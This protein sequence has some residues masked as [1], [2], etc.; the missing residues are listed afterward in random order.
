MGGLNEIFAKNDMQNIARELLCM[1][2]TSAKASRSFAASRQASMLCQTGYAM[3]TSLGRTPHS[4]HRSQTSSGFLLGR[5]I[6]G[7]VTSPL[8]KEEFNRRVA[9]L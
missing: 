4:P 8:P 3:E 5:V 9:F 1:K 2:M 7:G 6:P